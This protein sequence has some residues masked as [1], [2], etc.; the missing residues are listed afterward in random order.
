MTERFRNAVLPERVA[1]FLRGPWSQVLAEVHLRYDSLN[2]DPRGYLA[3]VDDLAWSVQPQVVPLDYARL[4]R[5]IPRLLGGLNEGLVLICYPQE[6]VSIFLDDLNVLH[7]KRLEAHRRALVVAR[8]LAA[9]ESGGQADTP[10]SAPATLPDTDDEDATWPLVPTP[11]RVR[12]AARIA[13]APHDL[14]LGSA[15]DLLLEGEWVRAKLTWSNNN[16]N[17]FM[18]VSGAGLAHAMSRRTMD[19]LETQGRIRIISAI[20]QVDLELED[21]ALD[22][23]AG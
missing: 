17:L 8:S 16:R 23:R 21:L 5:L 9:A 4:V 2:P 18:F 14:L 7:E 13:S 10:A 12:T 20:A 3:L 1:G 19:R 11:A 22:P 15:V 6:P